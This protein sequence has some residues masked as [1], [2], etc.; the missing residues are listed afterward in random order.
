MC[1]PHARDV[2]DFFNF[3]SSAMKPRYESVIISAS[4]RRMRFACGSEVLFDAYVD[5]H[6]ATCKPHTTARGEQW[7]LDDLSHPQQ[8][9]VETSRRIFTA[10]RRGQLHMINRNKGIAIHTCDVTLPTEPAICLLESK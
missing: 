7:R 3:D 4:Q 5:L 9:S 1:P 8:L 6:Y 2:I 10:R